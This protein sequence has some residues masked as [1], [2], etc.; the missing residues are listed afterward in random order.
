MRHLE[1]LH[2]N[3]TGSCASFCG[4]VIFFPRQRLKRNGT[5]L[6]NVLFDCFPVL[7]TDFLFAI[8][9]CF[10]PTSFLFTQHYLATKYCVLQFLLSTSRPL[11]SVR[12]VLMLLP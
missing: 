7:T 8:A 9:V 11:F 12:F 10:V 1:C 3:R 2:S 5:R 6:E 4:Q